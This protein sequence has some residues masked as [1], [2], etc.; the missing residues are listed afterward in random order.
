MT[1][2]DRLLWLLLARMPGATLRANTRCGTG[3]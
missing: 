1:L 3:D 2:R